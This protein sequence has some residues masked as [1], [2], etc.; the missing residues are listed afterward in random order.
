VDGPE[1]NYFEMVSMFIHLNPAR[2]GLVAVG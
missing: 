2:A 1:G